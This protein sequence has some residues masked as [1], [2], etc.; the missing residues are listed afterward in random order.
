MT[1]RHY[2]LQKQ[3]LLRF[4]HKSYGRTLSQSQVLKHFFPFTIIYFRI[5]MNGLGKNEKWR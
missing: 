3:E 4:V 2:N 5:F 1:A